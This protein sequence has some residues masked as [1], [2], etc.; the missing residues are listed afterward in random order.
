MPNESNLIPL[1]NRPP[2]ERRRIAS[3]G[4]KASSRMQKGRKLLRQNLEEIL[5]QD[6]RQDR[7]CDALIRQAE[8]GSVRAFSVIAAVLGENVQ[9]LEVGRMDAE[10]REAFIDAEAN[11]PLLLEMIRQ[12]MDNETGEPTLADAIGLSYSE[13]IRILNR[14]MEDEQRE[15]NERMIDYGNETDD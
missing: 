15:N 12:G 14:A 1:Q 2:E 10:Q 7:V 6:G 13:R 3:A 4:G 8:Q 11:Q 5:A 9:R